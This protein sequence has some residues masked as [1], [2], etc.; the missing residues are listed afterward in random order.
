MR[1]VPGNAEAAGTWNGFA[2]VHPAYQPRP[3]LPTGNPMRA[4]LLAALLAASLPAS[5]FPAAAQGAWVD[6]SGPQ[7][8]EIALTTRAGTYRLGVEVA[9]TE[10]ARNRGMAGRTVVPTGTGMLY[11][12]G[13]DREV[14]MWMKGNLVPL[15]M[16]FVREDGQVADVRPANQPGDLTPVVPPIPVRFV[17]ELPAGSAAAMDVRRLDRVDVDPPASPPLP[18]DAASAEMP[19]R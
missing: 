12:F 17:V 6:P 4:Y 2:G 5:P 9:A 11:D 8:R 15:D 10:A 3:S 13:E 16:I 7:R 1:A 18:A 14:G 19:A